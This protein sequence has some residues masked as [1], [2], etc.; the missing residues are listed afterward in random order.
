MRN[1]LLIIG[2]LSVFALFGCNGGPRIVDNQ[3]QVMGFPTY[4]MDS[5]FVYVGSPQLEDNSY[6]SGADCRPFNDVGGRQTS[7]LF[8]AT[9]DGKVKEVVA[10]ERNQ[11]NSGYY[12][13]ALKGPKVKF[14]GKEYVERFWEIANEKDGGVYTY[15]LKSEG[16]E[17]DGHNMAVRLLKRNVSDQNMINIAYGCSE[18]LIPENIK[19]DADAMQEFM[20]QRFLERITIPE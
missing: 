6:C 15:M 2:L 11:T 4:T 8:V 17:F 9:V 5:D 7:D 1:T 10:I 14:A 3:Y 18:D 12:W 19:G 13:R 16:Y 20:R